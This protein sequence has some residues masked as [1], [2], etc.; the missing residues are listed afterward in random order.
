[1]GSL[2]ASLH[3]TTTF[4]FIT[5][6]KDY[7]KKKNIA[8][9]FRFFYIFY[10]RKKTRHPTTFVPAPRRS[11]IWTHLFFILSLFSFF[12]SH[13]C[14]LFFFLFHLSSPL[15]SFPF[16]LCRATGGR[17]VWKNLFL[18]NFAPVSFFLF[19][20]FSLNYFLLHGCWFLRKTKHVELSDFIIFVLKKKKKK[21][22]PPLRASAYLERVGIIN[23]RDSP[24]WNKFC[25]LLH[26]TGWDFDRSSVWHWSIKG[27]PEGHWLLQKWRPMLKVFSGDD[28]RMIPDKV[29]RLFYCCQCSTVIIVHTHKNSS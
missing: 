13:C 29:C 16:F 7:T 1:M 12:L 4:H 27:G 25:I 22:S 8:Q 2:T 18:D 10:K 28:A 3:Q 11:A 15:I 24:I 17:E 23:F 14:V 26:K 19:H 20:A 9:G 5:K 6:Q 21:R